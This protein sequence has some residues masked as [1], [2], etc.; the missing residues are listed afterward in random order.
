MFPL[1]GGWWPM[2]S[3]KVCSIFYHIWLKVTI[4]FLSIMFYVLCEWKPKKSRNLLFYSKTTLHHTLLTLNFLV[5][6]NTL[7]KKNSLKV[8]SKKLRMLRH[9]FLILQV[10]DGS[11]C[12]ALLIW[13]IQ[14]IVF[15]FLVTCNIWLYCE[16][17][18]H[19]WYQWPWPCL[20][21][22]SVFRYTLP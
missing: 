21:V 7:Q 18:Q 19:L 10:F 8:F 14:H 9:G 3:H 5:V 12:L 17:L 1:G 20:F 2:T 16:V 11:F 4:C 13:L 6:F 22:H 15:V